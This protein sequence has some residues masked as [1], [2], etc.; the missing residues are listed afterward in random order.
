MPLEPG[1]VLKVSYD[2]KSLPW[3]I[4][5][6]EDVPLAP[7]AGVEVKD[8]VAGRSFHWRKN[9][10]VTLPGNIIVERD[11]KEERIILSND[12]LFEN[13]LA[14]LI[15]SEMNATCPPAFV[16]AQAVAARS[17]AF[18]FLRNKHPNEPFDVCNDDDCQRYQ[19]TTHLNE[20]ALAAV[21]QCRG[22]FLINQEGFV[23]PAYY[24]KCCGGHQELA[25][26]VFGFPVKGLSAELDGLSIEQAYCSPKY[27][28]KKA[29]SEYLGAVDEEGSYFR[30]QTNV[31]AQTIISS[32]QEKFGLADVSS[33]LDVIPGQQGV[34]GRIKNLTIVYMNEEDAKRVFLLSDQ[35]DIRKALHDTFLYSSAFDYEVERQ[36]DGAISSLKL[37]GKGWGHGV[38][39]CQLGALGMALEGLDYCKILR[40]YYRETSLKR[41]YP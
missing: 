7:R 19:G 20:E 4:Y 17:W 39:L 6:K 36:E 3:T 34:S 31:S 14:C 9:I 40:H 37:S 35:Y 2:D 24:S 13:Y 27:V 18:V 41:V 10:D 29:L 28:D 16:R 15:A 26:N 25:Q 38:G 1:Q 32:L 8:V 22:Q 30:W 33:L 5:A 23:L 21:A 12:V 11:K